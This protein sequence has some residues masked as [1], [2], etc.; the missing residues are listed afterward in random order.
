LL[1]LVLF[2]TLV[3]RMLNN[4]SDERTAYL[5]NDCLYLHTLSDACAFG[6]G[7]VER[8]FNRLGASLRNADW[9]L[10]GGPEKQT[11]KSLTMAH[12]QAW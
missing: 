3:I 6:T 1:L 2:K 9:C 4:P 7:A 11:Q 8:R 10:A 12:G 5:I